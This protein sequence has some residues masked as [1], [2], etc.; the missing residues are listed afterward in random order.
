MPPRKSKISSQQSN[1]QGVDDWLM[2]YA[3]MITLLLCFFA[4]FLSVSMPEKEAFKKARDDMLERFSNQESQVIV[5]TTADA[6]SKTGGIYNAMPSIIDQYKIGDDAIGQEKKTPQEETQKGINNQKPKQYEKPE[7]D[8]I[9]TLEIP[10][11]AFFASGSAQLSDDGKTLM[12]EII[13]KNLKAES[14]KDH[15]ITIEGHTDDV[16]IST[17]QFPSNW[18]LSTARAAS[19]V[20]YLIEKG[21]SPQRLS[22]SGYADS[23]PKVPNRDAAGKALPDNQAQNRRV[24]IK[25]QKIEQQP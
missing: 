20:R 13:E 16:P 10:S 21:L 7:G 19:V 15:M 8:R 12:D 1:H 5:L 9:I 24:V 22:A 23:F 6:Q 25:L 3:D 11:A 2:T 18:E 4:V 14:L 17:L